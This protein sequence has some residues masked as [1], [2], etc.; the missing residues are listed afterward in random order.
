MNEIGIF[1]F[2]LLYR[3]INALIVETQFDP[4]EYWQTLEPAYCLAFQSNCAYTWEWTRR[5]NVDSI[6]LTNIDLI[7]E[8]LHGPVR[9]YVPILPIYALYKL[10]R[11]FHLDTTWSIAR[12]PLILNAALVAAPTDFGVFYMSRYIRRIKKIRKNEFSWKFE[13]WALLA[14]ITNWFNGYALVRT[15]S[16]ST[17]AALLCVGMTLLCPELFGIIHSKHEFKVRLMAR[18]AFLLGGISIVIRFTALASWV[19]IGIIICLRRKSMSSRIYYLWHMSI[20][21]GAMGVFLGCILDRI[22]YGFWAIPFLGS[23]HFN[24]LLGTLTPIHII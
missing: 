6:N 18:L 22:Y 24:V 19:P 1:S 3:V 21:S 13:H 23:F 20:V 4:D 8:A 12:A 9:S 7:E 5:R 10:L 15:Y 11:A 14:S 16:N 17:E 2:I